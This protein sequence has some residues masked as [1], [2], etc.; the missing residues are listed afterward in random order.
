MNE[1]ITAKKALAIMNERA[2]TPEEA[3][4]IDEQ[5][6]DYDP[7]NKNTISTISL[8]GQD[9]RGPYSTGKQHKR[10]PGAE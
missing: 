8:I 5:I 4:L 10:H 6:I 2:L 9:R 7:W 1:T 3:K